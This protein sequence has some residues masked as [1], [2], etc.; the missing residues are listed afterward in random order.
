MR[1]IQAF[2]I[3]HFVQRKGHQF[4]KCRALCCLMKGLPA[5][6]G[7]WNAVARC[8]LLTSGEKILLLLA[9]PRFLLVRLT[10]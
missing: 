7:L 2:R 3:F 8:I 1:L 5:T 6:N 9:F 10:L 4:Q